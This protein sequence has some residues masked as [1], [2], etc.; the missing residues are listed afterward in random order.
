MKGNSIALKMSPKVRWGI[1]LGLALMLALATFGTAFA[2]D[3]T[4]PDVQAVADTAGDTAT[5]LNVLW[6]LIAG[7]WCSS[8]RRASRW[9][10]PA[11]RATRTW[12]TP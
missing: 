6:V 4:P 3:G 1:I 11:S 5:S 2:Q 12:C 10:R 7:A 9:W 8:C